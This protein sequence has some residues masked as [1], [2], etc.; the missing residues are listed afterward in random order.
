MKTISEMRKEVTKKDFIVDNL[1]KSKGLYCLVARPKVGKSLLALQL[2]N[3]IATGTTFLGFRTSPSPVLYIST[4]MNSTQIIDRIDKM[5]LSFNDDNFVMIEQNPSERKLN[6][7]DLQLQFQTFSNEY[8]GK[9]VIIDMFSGIDLNNGYDLNNY[10]DMGQVVIPKF[11]ELCKKYDFTILLVHHLNKNNT[12]L[13]STAI[14]GSVDGKITLKQ[15][16]NL[17]NKII[18]NYESRDYEG[19]DLVLKR[20]D[21]LLFELSEVECDDLNYNILTFLNYAIKQKDFSFS[22]SD[23]TSKLNLQIT[24]SAFGKLLNNNIANLEKEG[25]HIEQKRTATER[26]YIAKYEEPT[27]ENE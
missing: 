14:D 13:G 18:L 26:V 8:N 7:M 21:N 10:Q 19:L 1:M 15:D 11:R 9:F 2:A 17:K 3:S 25:L 22:A 12:S 16:S 20:N 24:P 23:I 5:N 4:E 6:L 27:Y